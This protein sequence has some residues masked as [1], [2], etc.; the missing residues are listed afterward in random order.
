[1]RKPV[2]ITP[3]RWPHHQEAPQLSW[4]FDRDADLLLV[5]SPPWFTKM[6]PLGV[7]YLLTSL[8]TRGH[9][10]EVADLNVELFNSAGEAAKQYWA[11][12][13]LNNRTPP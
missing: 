9:K 2:F 10:V 5:M 13:F 3:T 4:S 7:A 8:K 12:E 6:P 1:M 11:I